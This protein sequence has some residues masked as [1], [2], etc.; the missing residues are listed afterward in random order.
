SGG[1]AFHLIRPSAPVKG[2]GVLG[3]EP[4]Y[5]GVIGDRRVVVVLIHVREAAVV[6]RV[7]VLG[8][9]PDCL[10]VFRNRAVGVVLVVIVNA[11]ANERRHRFGLPTFLGFRLV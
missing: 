3:I 1:V 6:E 10:R 8:V 5:L 7:G 9:E 11:P 2:F 4:D